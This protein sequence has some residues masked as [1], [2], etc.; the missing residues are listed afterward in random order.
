MRECD[1]IAYR[2]DLQ[3]RIGQIQD[4]KGIST[5]K[6]LSGVES[7][8]DISTEATMSTTAIVVIVSLC[9][10]HIVFGTDI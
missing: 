7:S 10:D 3:Q 6:N 5:M 4:L 9:H 2:F 8:E 1:S